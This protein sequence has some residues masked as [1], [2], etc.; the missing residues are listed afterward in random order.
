MLLLI[1]LENPYCGQSV[2]SVPGIRK[3]KIGHRNHR[4]LIKDK[5]CS[6]EASEELQ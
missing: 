6:E 5:A 2:D 4:D 3:D 1:M